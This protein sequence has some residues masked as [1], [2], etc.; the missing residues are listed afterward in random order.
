MQDAAAVNEK[1][2]KKID[3]HEDQS[4]EKS[5]ATSIQA[6]PD[7][8]AV[9]Y[10]SDRSSTSILSSEESESEHEIRVV[11]KNSALSIDSDTDSR[12][13]KVSE[14]EEE[15][16]EEENEE[17]EEEKKKRVTLRK[18]IKRSIPK[19][20][21]LKIAE[22]KAVG[23]KA[24]KQQVLQRLS[25]GVIKDSEMLGKLGRQKEMLDKINSSIT[26]K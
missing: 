19:K 11:V 7:P 24:F 5:C 2:L 10:A 25:K 3:N 12:K 13:R 14:E 9:E 23:K 4:R 18:R 6:E 20:K 1:N 17:E 16:E 8:K 15:E 21:N 26:N 22:K